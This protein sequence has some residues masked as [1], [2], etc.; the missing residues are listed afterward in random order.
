MRWRSVL[1]LTQKMHAKKKNYCVGG[2][3]G[4]I[5]RDPFGNVDSSA[6]GV[7]GEIIQRVASIRQTVQNIVLWCLDG[8]GQR[9]QSI[10]EP[11][12]TA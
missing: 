2:R 10:S 12:A 3:L 6:D 7:D 5:L 9:I 4:R 1:V 11:R 8:A